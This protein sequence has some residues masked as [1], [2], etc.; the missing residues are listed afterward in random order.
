MENLR[1][2]EPA[3]AEAFAHDGFFVR[4]LF[5]VEEAASMAAEFETLTAGSP[6]SPN[7]AGNY[8]SVMDAD[9]ALSAAIQEWSAGKLSPA[10]DRVAVGWKPI[11]TGVLIK[12]AHGK[13]T[14]FHLHQPITDHPFGLSVIGWCALRDC[15][16]HNGCLRVIPG[17]HLLFRH[18]GAG[19]AI[20]PEN[21][22]DQKLL[23][24]RH[25][26]PVPLKSGEAIFFHNG[27]LHGA[28]PNSTGQARPAIGIHFTTPDQNPALY[29]PHGDGMAAFRLPDGN[30]TGLFGANRI[31]ELDKADIL[32]TFP[33]WNPRPNLA[34]V[35][36]LL[37]ARGPR[38]RED[39]EPLDLVRHLATPTG[40]DATED[41]LRPLA[42]RRLVAKIPGARA[43]YRLVRSRPRISK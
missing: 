37:Q 36:A 31:T 18:I 4:R 23:I 28:H 33:A 35:E 1:F 25:A 27:L 43:V 8:Y 10:M 42:F 14:R 29:R 5:E 7:E 12:P 41:A 32:R 16:E 19:S 15:D 39:Y 2:L 40:P 21:A 30:Y 13:E 22:E 17:S 34:Q 24:Q 9:Q 11:R 20:Y 38:A 26:I 3:D 6:L